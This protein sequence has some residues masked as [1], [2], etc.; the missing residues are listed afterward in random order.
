[1]WGNLDGESFVDPDCT[2]G[3][4]LPCLLLRCG[5]VKFLSWA[6]APTKSS[7]FHP[8]R[9]VLD[10]RNTSCMTQRRAHAFL[11]VS[12]KTN[13]NMHRSS[14]VNPRTTLTSHTRFPTK[15]IFRRPATTTTTTVGATP[16]VVEG[17]GCATL[18]D[19]YAAQPTGEEAV[20]VTDASSNKLAE[21]T[22]PTRFW[23]VRER[24]V[25]RVCRARVIGVRAGT[26]NTNML[27]RRERAK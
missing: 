20:F 7:S 17:G 23:L 14:F 25:V 5:T 21:G 24:Y 2:P 3:R 9:N 15:T 18:S 1:M 22:P 10:R 27:L 26:E 11:A 12:P 16:P 13:I 8:V 19:V 4:G 6:C